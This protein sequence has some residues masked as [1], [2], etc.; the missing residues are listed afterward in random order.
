[1]VDARVSA[2][3][4]GPTLIGFTMNQLRILE[5]VEFTTAESV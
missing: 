1:L 4:P 5:K 3:T 2:Q